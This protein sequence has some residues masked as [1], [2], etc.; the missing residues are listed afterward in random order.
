[1]TN[2][3]YLILILTVFVTGFL[4]ISCIEDKPKEPLLVDTLQKLPDN[5]EI[6]SDNIDT[7]RAAKEAEYLANL[8]LREKKQEVFEKVA[9]EKNLSKEALIEFL[10]VALDGFKALPSST[11]RTIENDS[12]ITISARKQFIDDKRRTILFDIFDYGRGNRVLNSHIYEKVP[13]DLDA[14]AYPYE[15]PNAKGFYYWLDQRFY[16][17]IEV[18]ADNRFVIM[19]RTNGIE[20][21]DKT[22]ENYIKKINITKLIKSGK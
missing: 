21:D 10:P 1:M 15:Q 6:Q 2:R 13:E 19:V 16:G 20:R 17:H 8:K 11:G 9:K 7:L 4:F 3:F 12:A 14:P 22:L 18:L 5:S